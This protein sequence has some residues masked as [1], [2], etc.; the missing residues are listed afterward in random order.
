[1]QKRIRARV[2]FLEELSNEINQLKTDILFMYDLWA[3]KSPSKSYEV[4]GYMR[5]ATFLI[6][7]MALVM[8]DK[9]SERVEAMQGFVWLY[10][11]EKANLTKLL[12]VPG[13]SKT[14]SRESQLEA[15]E[16]KSRILK[17]VS[18]LSRAI[19]PSKMFVECNLERFLDIVMK[20]EPYKTFSELK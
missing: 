9:E 10:L 11:F 16:A 19:N 4:I 12:R 8:S 7:R 17:I 1:M 20:M 6:E 5:S 2:Y 13:I 14:Y 18:L 3:R 15:K